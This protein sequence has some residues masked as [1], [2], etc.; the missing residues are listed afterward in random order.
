[1]A[2]NAAFAVARRIEM[3]GLSCRPALFRLA[4]ITGS[5]PLRRGSPLNWPFLPGGTSA[6]NQVENLACD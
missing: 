5:G 6:A 3:K 2:R 1:M 4:I